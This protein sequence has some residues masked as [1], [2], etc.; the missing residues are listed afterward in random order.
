MATH[1]RQRVVCEYNTITYDTICRNGSKFNDLSSEEKENTFCVVRCQKHAT[2]DEWIQG[3][4]CA[5]WAHWEW[6]ERD[7]R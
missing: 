1:W 6:E 5:I 7:P 2:K 4:E 3:I